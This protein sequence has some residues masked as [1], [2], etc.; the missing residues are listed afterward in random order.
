MIEPFDDCEIERFL[1]SNPGVMA[2]EIAR[3]LGT[4][5][6]VVNSHLYRQPHTFSRDDKSCW[7]LVNP[8]RMTITL[9][10]TWVDGASYEEALA[11]TGSPLDFDCPV[12]EI[13]MPKGCKIMIDAVARILALCNQLIMLERSVSSDSTH[14]SRR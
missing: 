5:K 11:V 4:Q 13:V 6:S 10:N 9:K 1:R 7:F 3:H 2:K 12:V 14:A 8:D